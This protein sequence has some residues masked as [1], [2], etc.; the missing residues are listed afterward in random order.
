MTAGDFAGARGFS[1]R[2][3]PLRGSWATR[4]TSRSALYSRR[5]S[6]STSRDR[7]HLAERWFDEGLAIARE[8]GEKTLLA[9]SLSRLGDIGR[10]AGDFDRAE[11]LQ[12][13]AL[14][15]NR[16]LSNRRAGA[17]CLEGLGARR[18][19]PRRRA[20]DRGAYGGGPARCASRSARTGRP[21]SARSSTRRSTGLR[22]ELRDGAF[23]QASAAAATAS[24]E[25]AAGLRRRPGSGGTWRLTPP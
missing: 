14:E 16:E 17:E 19:F 22:T 2:A 3:W 21:M 23:A 18:P 11:A 13:E 15:I 25:E 5:A 9:R 20:P 1:P 4:A 8:L 7:R 10:R 12:L 24:L 6:W